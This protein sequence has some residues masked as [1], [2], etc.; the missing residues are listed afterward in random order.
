M[1]RMK[2]MRIAIPYE[3]GQIFKRFGHA[4]Q[5]KFYDV[6]DGRILREQVI[7]TPPKKGH[8][9]YAGFLK[10]MSADVLICDRIG[11]GGKSALKA[12][13]IELYAGIQGNADDAAKALI[14]G[15]L[16]KNDNEKPDRKFADQL[17]VPIS[18][19]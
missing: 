2:M 17:N 11:D 13:D 7:D 12:A 14:Q 18:F 3:N 15:T 9:V 19:Y 10:K 6:E 5:F 4:P 1:K 8:A 16:S